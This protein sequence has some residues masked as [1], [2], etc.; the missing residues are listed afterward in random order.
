MS[1]DSMPWIPLQHRLDQ[2]PLILAGP[3][4]RRTEPTAVTVWLAL[5]QACQV[6]LRVYATDYGNG[7][8]V[9]SLVLSGEGHTVALGEHLHIVAV[10][11][12]SDP[13]QGL[14]QGLQSGQIY[15]YDLG[16]E[17]DTHSE[18]LTLQ[19]A[20]NTAQL[21]SVPISYFEHQ[22]PTFLLPPQD[23]N[24]LKLI[25]GSCRKTH[26]G[27]IDAVPI[28]DDLL[29]QTARFPQ[30]RPHQL[31]FTGDQIYGDDV[32]DP[33][34]F[35]LTDAGDTL[36]GWEEELPINSTP[37]P[38][39][40]PLK[41][42]HLPPGER[43][44]VAENL[45]GFTAGLHNKPDHTNSHLLSLGEYSTAYLFAWSPV[46]W[47]EFP[48]G[49]ELYR[50][51]KRI[52]IWD[53]EVATL[54]NFLHSLWKV[55]RALAN[56]PTYMIFDDHDISDDWYLNQAWCLRVLGKPL[57]RRA[58]QNGMLAYAIAQAW[59][60]TPEQFAPGTVGEQLLQAA[61]IWSASKG[62]DQAASE[63]IARSLG[64]P[65]LDASGM[66]R[67]RKDEQV[68]ILDHPSDSLQWHYTI[69]SNCHEVLVLDTRTWRGYP[70]AADNLAPPMLLSPSAFDH[71]I[72]QPLQ[73][74]QSQLQTLVIAPTNLIHLRI[75]DWAQQLSLQNGNVFGNDVGDA[76]NLHKEALSELLAALFENR[77]RVVVLSGDIH[78][79]FAARLNYWTRHPDDKTNAQ[80]LVQLTASAFKNAELKT[81]IIQTKLKSIA[82]EPPQEWV[83]W[84][85]SPD[86]WEVQTLPG[87][88]RWMK[89]LPAQLPLIRQFRPT[90]GN[91][92]LAWTIAARDPQ[93]LPDWHYRI[94]W[95][96]RQPAHHPTWGRKL[97][98]LKLGQ[99][100]RKSWKHA[101]S[102]ISWLWY[103][104]WLQEGEE[105]VG[106]SN[107]GFVQ[108]RG[109]AE[110]NAHPIV[111]Q[112]LYWCP[113][114]RPDSIVSSR[115][116]AKLEPEEA[117][118]PFPLLSKLE[119]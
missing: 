100:R 78:Y 104:R 21:P 58:V 12:K 62:T 52:K 1:P 51:S 20:L 26:G 118:T 33:W 97:A 3:V 74:T 84:N 24:E 85:H 15:A 8:V 23:I 116:D 115:F 60:N 69:R 114:W 113:P 9:G 103:N 59:G 73:H 28:L 119:R 66:P 22:L 31:F 82:P 67:F 7:L 39:I 10:T 68:W 79:G 34:L 37:S 111:F 40:P 96:K 18:A 4:L 13:T 110:P 105:V 30:Q 50:D 44:S 27:G 106:E 108:F 109:F 32:A 19:Q 36:L 91:S 65:D 76:W 47:N 112:D 11:A 56:I 81:Q 117:A 102:W 89:L 6:E 75:I 92:T 17:S 95:I 88:V 99:P 94:E 16:F 46:L 29:E 72:R 25:H 64:L 63:T 86:L 93:S 2:L 55:R 48:S 53:Q 45:A 38:T 41:A 42:K 49:Q 87:I 57:G 101:W 107:L 90:Q 83:G 71:Q 43:T 98:W 5:R 80:V 35:A 70:I 61:Q 77:D 54:Q 14:Q